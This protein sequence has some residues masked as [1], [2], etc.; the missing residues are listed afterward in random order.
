MEIEA[1][2]EEGEPE[3]TAVDPIP[4]VA[5]NGGGEPESAAADPIPSVAP[6]GGGAPE[7]AEFTAF[8]KKLAD[9]NVPAELFPTTMPKGQKSYTVKSN[10]GAVIEVHHVKK[11]Y[12]VKKC[13]PVEGTGLAGASPNFTWA[14]Y[15]GSAESWAIV[16]EK[17]DPNWVTQTDS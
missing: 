13:A 17:A 16:K 15:G 1:S 10:A 5:P 3:S 12:F 2:T 6:N 8:L 7:S 9:V 14:K 11:F 4:S